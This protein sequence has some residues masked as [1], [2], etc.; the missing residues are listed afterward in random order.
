M[1]LP[2]PHD[3][4]ALPPLHD[5]NQYAFDCPDP[6]ATGDV[7]VV[8]PN[9]QMSFDDFFKHWHCLRDSFQQRT[10]YE[11]EALFSLD[12]NANIVNPADAESE[13]R[14]HHN[15]HQCANLLRHQMS[16][17][18]P[19]AD[20]VRV[21]C[22]PCL[23]DDPA[24]GTLQ[25]LVVNVRPAC[26]D[27]P[28]RYLQYQLN[29]FDS[30][31]ATCCPDCR[32]CMVPGCERFMCKCDKLAQTRVGEPV[33]YAYDDACENI[34]QLVNS[35]GGG[36]FVGDGILDLIEKVDEFV[37]AVSDAVR[38]G[39]ALPKLSDQ[40]T[41]ED[42]P[43]RVKLQPMQCVPGDDDEDESD[44]DAACHRVVVTAAARLKGFL[45]GPL[46][47]DN[48]WHF[49]SDDDGC[50]V[51]AD[52]LPGLEIELRAF[53]KAVAEWQPEAAAYVCPRKQPRPPTVLVNA[54]IADVVPH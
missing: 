40:V 32:S 4:V 42:A 30:S 8:L 31:N 47:D 48:R 15:A 14:T 3:T 46:E 44:A 20:Y 16:T 54:D 39:L 23:R 6:G 38:V 17:W 29:P 2:P 36:C 37:L 22:Q 9:Q 24:R 19:Y 7:Y 11:Q 21:V 28:L 5:I 41:I 33:I 18:F 50:D 12:A 10:P 43:K 52:Y 27:E 49:G 26:A 34:D 35:G 1:S 45:A 51:V 53:V 13:R 25:P